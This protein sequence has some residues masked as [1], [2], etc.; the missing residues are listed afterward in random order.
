MEAEFLRS[1]RIIMQPHSAF[2]QARWRFFCTEDNSSRM[3][4][5]PEAAVPRESSFWEPTPRT[6]RRRLQG[7]WGAPYGPEG[8]LAVRLASRSVV[9]RARDSFDGRV[10][11]PPSA[12]FVLPF[13]KAAEICRT[14]GVQSP[15]HRRCNS[16]KQKTCSIRRETTLWPPS[17][18][19][20]EGVALD[21]FFPRKAK[22]SAELKCEQ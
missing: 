4:S 5:A 13:A 17:L 1:R 9:G 11:A 16:T 7:D 15:E 12:P 19:Q 22:G 3:R 2:R 18:V 6:A 21:F 8:L 14:M 20:K 10:K